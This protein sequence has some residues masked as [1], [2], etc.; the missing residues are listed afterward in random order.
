[1][2]K[3]CYLGDILSAGGAAEANSITQ[4]RI[5]WK[6]FGELLP[7]FTSRVFLRKMRGNIYEACVRRAM[8]CGSEIWLVKIEDTWRPQQTEM[9]MARWMC[10]I[11]VSEQRPSDEMRD[12]L[13]IQDVYGVSGKCNLGGL[14]T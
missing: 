10:G 6:K 3:F 12:R 14:V 2:D 11:I 8:L 7:L 4:I 13:G 1:M 5:G 9:Q